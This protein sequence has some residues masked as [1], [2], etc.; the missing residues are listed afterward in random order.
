MTFTQFK[1]RIISLAESC[2]ISV[3]FEY[4]ED[5]RRF[6]AFLSDGSRIT[7]NSTSPVKTIRRRNGFQAQFV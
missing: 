6:E 7:G 5:K 4:D 2:G 1:A 3:R